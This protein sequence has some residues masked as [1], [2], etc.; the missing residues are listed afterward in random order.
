MNQL[1]YGIKKAWLRRFT[2]DL[3]VAEARQGD[4]ILKKLET[5][6]LRSKVT[7]L[8]RQIIDYEHT[9]FCCERRHDEE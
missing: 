2:R 6:A 7:E 9:V 8:E 4:S 1:Q 5:D 3:E